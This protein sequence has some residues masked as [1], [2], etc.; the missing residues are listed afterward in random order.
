MAGQTII[1]LDIRAQYGINIIA[2]KRAK[3][4]YSS[5]DP[6]INIEIGTF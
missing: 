3:R 6:N 5:P 1:E 2:I 4:I